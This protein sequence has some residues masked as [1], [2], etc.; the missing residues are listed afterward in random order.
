MLLLIVHGGRS[1]IAKF[2]VFADESGWFRRGLGILFLII[3]LM[4][5]SGL[6]KKLETVALE[7][8]NL[9][10]IE[11]QLIDSLVPKKQMSRESFSP[12]I[13][14]SASSGTPHSLSIG[15]GSSIPSSSSTDASKTG[16]SPPQIPSST[17]ISPIVTPVAPPFPLSVKTPYD[18]PEIALTEWINSN[19]LTMKSLR[20]KVVI[21][22]FWTYSCIN[23]QRTLPYMTAW[24]KKYR[25]Q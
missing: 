14:T 22:D 16:V 23:C 10:F 17:A 4:I 6:D 8:F 18:A 2:R 5:I 11:N 1:I 21:I 15:S 12:A 3:G 24:D 19:P 25:D 13:V 9:S 20:G 7:Y